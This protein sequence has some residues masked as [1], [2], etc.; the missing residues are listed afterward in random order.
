MIKWI[1]NVK[2][3]AN[4]ELHV[5]IKLCANVESYVNAKCH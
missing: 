4:I 3:C 5:N 2:S 1:V